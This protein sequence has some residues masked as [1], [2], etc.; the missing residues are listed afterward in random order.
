VLLS[1]LPPNFDGASHGHIFS[2]HPAFPQVKFSK[3]CMN[4]MNNLQGCDIDQS[5][6]N[7]R[8]G[9]YHAKSLPSRLI[10]LLRFPMS[11]SHDVKTQDLD[12]ILVVIPV[13]NEASTIR[14]VLC[15]LQHH[16]LSNIRVVDNG[17]TDDSAAIATQAGAQVLSEPKAGYGQACWR[18]LQGLPTSIEWILFCDGDGS[19]DLSMLPAFLTAREQ[20]D[21]ILGDR[22]ATAAGRAA[23][24]PVQ[25]MGNRLAT[26]LI[27][28]GWGDEFKDLG[29]FRL[30]R[31]SVLDSLSMRD[32]SFGWTL[33]MQVRALEH[34]V[35]ILE[36]PVPYRT[37][38]GGTSKISGNLWGSVQAGRVI[39]QTLGALYLHRLFRYIR[40]AMISDRPTAIAPPFRAIQ[41]T[42]SSAFGMVAIALLI[43]VGCGLMMPFG[44]F[45]EP[46]AVPRLW[47]ALGFM[48][49]G[50]MGSWGVTQLGGLPFWSVTLLSRALLLPMYPGSDIWRYLW[51]GYIQL[52]GV[53]PYQ[54]APNAPEL[55]ALHTSWWVNVNLPE[56]SAIYPPLTQLGFRLLAALAPSVLLFKLAFVAADVLI[57][58][59]LA[60][61]FSYHRV[62]R[63]AWNPVILYSFAGGGHYDSWFL[64]AL[65]V[66]W[67]ACDDLRSVRDQRSGS[68][69]HDQSGFGEAFRSA[70]ALGL[71]IALKWMTLPL[72]AFWFGRVLPSR[73]WRRTDGAKGVPSVPSTVPTQQPTAQGSWTTSLLRLLSLGLIGA[74]PMVISALPFCRPTSCPLIPTGSVFVS[75][76]R[77]AELIPYWIAKVWDYSRWHN[78]LYLIPLAI[79]LGVLIGLDGRRPVGDHRSIQRPTFQAFGN[80][81]EGYFWA[82][83]LLSPIVHVWYFTWLVPF[84]V[85]SGHWGTRLISLSG[86]AYFALPHQMAL[87]DFSWVLGDFQRWLLWIPGLIGLI[88]HYLRRNN[89]SV[90]LTSKKYERCGLGD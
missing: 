54:F 55:E 77:S 50:F 67:L 21:F 43:L 33:E 48:G 88:F 1:E 23:M 73:L 12:S 80:F 87:G 11:I 15:A 25:Q 31:R 64:L 89:H 40:S 42:C 17:S 71:S 6:T 63:Y 74:L 68:T 49:L 30:I 86:F 51:E 27:R 35:R 70:I 39:L 5:E 14:D 46:E 28:W 83:L 79:A 41:Q 62:T 90:E 22:S 4:N 32:R 9:R 19:D 82:L 58:Y 61:R 10:S 72:L 65:V 26:K 18:G 34:R 45:R 60:R 76:G 53:S 75:H 81:A 69:A 8:A 78:W 59:L 2:I 57:C 47:F 24:T 7:F 20:Y 38:R 13:R 44:D 37:R 36:L 29:P 85:A 66:A 84:A 56:V 16:G 3:L 52:Q